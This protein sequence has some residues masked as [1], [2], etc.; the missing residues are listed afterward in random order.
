MCLTRDIARTRPSFKGFGRSERQ[1]RKP[2][3]I[4]FRF[5]AHVGW[6]WEG[7]LDRLFDP[8]RQ[9]AFGLGTHLHVSCFAILEHD[10]RRN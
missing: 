6:C 5:K 10:E 4:G 8:L 7:S 3:R 9:F 1:K 2:G